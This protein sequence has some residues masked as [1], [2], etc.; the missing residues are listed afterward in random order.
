[1]TFVSGLK[2]LRTVL[3]DRHSL[4]PWFTGFVARAGI[5]AAFSVVFLVG[6]VW[7]MKGGPDIFNRYELNNHNILSS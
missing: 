2:L 3:V 4:P 6:R 7:L 5:L 1:M